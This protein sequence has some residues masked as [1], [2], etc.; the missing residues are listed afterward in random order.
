[1]LLLDEKTRGENIHLDLSPF[2]PLNE[3]FRLKETKSLIHLELLEPNF[4]PYQLFEENL[5]FYYAHQDDFD[6]QL[7][8][9]KD[10]LGLGDRDSSLLLLRNKLYYLGDLESDRRQHSDLFDH[11]LEAALKNFQ[12]RH[13]LEAN[14][15]LDA[16]SVKTINRPLK[17]IIA[18]MQLNLERWR[19]LPSY[20]GYYIA[21]ANLAA[22]EMSLIKEDSL[23]LR[24]NIVCGKVNRKTPVFSEKMIYIDINPTWTVPPTILQNDILPA[25]RRSSNYL[26]KTNIKVLDLSTGKYVSGAEINWAKASSYKYI[27]GPGLS[28]SLGVVKFI[29]PNDYYIFFHDT[30]HKEHFPLKVRAYSS[31]CVRLS[32]PLELASILLSYNEKSYTTEDIDT[33]VVSQKTTRILLDEQPQVYIHY[34][35]Q[36]VKDGLLYQYPDIYSYNGDLKK[37]F[38]LARKQASS[39]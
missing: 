8:V 27:Q 29:F 13:L 3:L 15:I 7:L 21:F 36:E 26:S 30:P 31:G 32:Q 4:L 23:L 35:T 16:L 25:I 10:S 6:E 38:D 33:I 14:G 5:Q 37:A 11:D 17:E 19:W 1:G 34:L 12:K 18:E 9:F 39:R 2:D 28:N 24:Q 22:F 20:L